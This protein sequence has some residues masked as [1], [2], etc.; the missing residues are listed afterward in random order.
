ML[1]S[2]P[3]VIVTKDGTHAMLRP[4]ARGDERALEA[5]FA[6][7]PHEERWFRRERVDDP[8]VI[9]QWMA[10]LDYDRVLPMVAVHAGDGRIIAN[11]SLHRRTFGCRKHIGHV[12]VMV[13]PAFR[14]QRLGTWMLLDMVK[15]AMEAGLEKLVAEL[16]AGV[17][18][19]AIRAA[20]RLDFFREA[21]L[22]DYVK[23]QDGQ[24]RDLVIMVKT[25]HRD[26]SDF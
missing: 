15:L 21:V 10:N 14:S 5:F 13:D 24:P 4:L 2:Y 6:R 1:E 12:R 11:L 17:E 3:K 19:A 22:R 16:V 23:D 9:R 18:E 26:W 7:I 8:E 25:L 20:A